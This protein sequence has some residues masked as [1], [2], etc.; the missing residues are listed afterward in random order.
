MIKNDDIFS[1]IENNYRQKNAEKRRIRQEYLARAETAADNAARLILNGQKNGI[2]HMDI[3]EEYKGPIMRYYRKYWL[4]YMH[5]SLIFISI[6]IFI[7]SFYTLQATYLIFL[8]FLVILISSEDVYMVKLVGFGTYSSQE[9]EVIKAKLFSSR[10]D[11]KRNFGLMVGFTV[12]SIIAHT[13]TF[14][15][16]NYATAGWIFFQNYAFNS[17]NELY[18]II[19]VIL[20]LSMS[21]LRFLR[22]I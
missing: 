17:Q 4:R 13:F 15:I 9:L 21:F 18:A 3:G 11:I 19:N 7:I 10:Y 22:K 20:I 6:L 14:S 5:I 1:N 12:I 16:L 8:A 2:E